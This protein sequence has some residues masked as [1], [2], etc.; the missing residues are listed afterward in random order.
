MSMPKYQDSLHRYS[1]EYNIIYRLQGKRIFIFQPLYHINIFKIIKNIMIL[2]L[3][4]L[5]KYL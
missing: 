4:D 2:K 5:T 3:F 1:A